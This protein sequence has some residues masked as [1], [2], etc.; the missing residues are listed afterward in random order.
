MLIIGRLGRGISISINKLHDK[1]IDNLKLPMLNI[2]LGIIR[3]IL[4]FERSRGFIFFL[5]FKKDG[6]ANRT[7]DYNVM[8]YKYGNRR[9]ESAIGIEIDKLMLERSKYV[10]F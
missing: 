6:I 9:E 7:Q 3:L 4:F 10:I 5:C 1:F 2:H 8:V